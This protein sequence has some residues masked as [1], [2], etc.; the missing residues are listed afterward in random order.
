MK[1]RSVIIL[2]PQYYGLDESIKR[3]FERLGYESTLFGLNMQI[4]ERVLGKITRMYG[5]TRSVLNPLLLAAL[6][7]ENRR[8]LRNAKQIKPALIFIVKGDSILPQTLQSL[9][10]I[11]IPCI[12]YQWDDP[13]YS[14]DGVT[15]GD[16]FRTNNFE[17]GMKHYSRIFVFD[18]HYVDVVKRRG[19]SNVAY[20]PLAA[21]DEIYRNVQLTDEERGRY[22]FDVSFVGMP[23]Q[24]RI[25]LF[26]ELNNVRIGVFGDYWDRHKDKMK[27]DY[28]RGKASGETV[29][30]IYCASKINLNI[31]HPQSL[32]GV[33]TRTFEIPACKAFSMVD[34]KEGLEEMFNIGDEIVCYK[35]M[36]EL[37]DKIM[38]YIKNDRERLKIAEQGYERVRKEHTWYHRMKIVLDSLN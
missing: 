27:G 25:N 18:K 30:K 38:F 2:A 12:S 36:D 8:Y 5:M 11:E 35:N 6:R 17:R 22:A 13:F 3:A 16:E 19:I 23:F 15:A 33:N 14:G 1:S 34:Y 10:K 21:D 28:Y 37:K 32:Y 7:H 4:W 20:L 29:K 24:N 9:K 26:N 31:N